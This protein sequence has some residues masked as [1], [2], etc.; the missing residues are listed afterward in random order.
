MRLYPVSS[1]LKLVCSQKLSSHTFVFCHNL[2]E[3]LAWM[4]QGRII[5]KHGRCRCQSAAQVIS[6]IVHNVHGATLFAQ[7]RE[8]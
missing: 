6:L 4:I 1:K 3:V 2:E 8:T 5:E 7:D